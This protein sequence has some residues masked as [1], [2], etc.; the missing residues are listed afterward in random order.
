MEEQ[1]EARAGGRAAQEGSQRRASEPRKL[2]RPKGSSGNMPPQTEGAC[3]VGLF[4]TWKYQIQSR[5]GHALAEV[6]E[7]ALCLSL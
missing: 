3:H 7:D 2:H 1:G 5:Q 4:L 6:G